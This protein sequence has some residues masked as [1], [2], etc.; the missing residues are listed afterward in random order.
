VNVIVYGDFNCLYSYLASQRADRLVQTGTAEIDWRA[1]E[2]D[3][4]L[5]VAGIRADQG[6][7]G[8]ERELAEAAAL[9]L[10]GERLPA[11]PPPTVSNTRAA[12]AAYA[13]AVTDGVEDELRRHLFDAIWAQRRN[14]SSPNE[15]R[16]VITGVV[17]PKDPIYFH[18]MSPD[19]PDPILHDPDPR[20]IVRREGGTVTPDGGPLTT[21][22]YRRIQQ[23]RQRWLALPQQVIPV[24]ISPSGTVHFGADG[25]RCLAGIAGSPADCA[26]SRARLV[27]GRLPAG[28]VGAC[29]L[30][31]PHCARLLTAGKSP[32]RR[33]R[34]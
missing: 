15:V 5:P 3:R 11:A 16:Q 28:P 31:G 18:L 2:H 30:A 8:W 17:W 4:Q 21:T 6:D 1:V 34:C 25:L 13:E 32:L 14:L 20:R 9:A 10:P 27:S 29:P 24:V 22:G 12:V 26:A 33:R 7:P 23:W 19:L